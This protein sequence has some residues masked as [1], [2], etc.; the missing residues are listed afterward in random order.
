VRRVWLVQLV[1]GVLLLSGCSGPIAGFPDIGDEISDGA[2]ADMLDRHNAERSA[3]GLPALEVNAHLMQIAQAQAEYNDER[4]ELSHMD[5]R[6]G[7]VRDRADAAGYSAAD[8][9]ENLGYGES[10]R[11]VFNDWLASPAHAATIR[12]E[13]FTEVGLGRA[14]NGI[15][16]FWVVVFGG[17]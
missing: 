12:D 16:E 17:R 8:I 13:R 2:I 11:E 10:G 7:L 15:F 14:T 4:G 5:A 9:A 1:V 6:G 3:R